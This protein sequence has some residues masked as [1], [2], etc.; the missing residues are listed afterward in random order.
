[1][2]DLT[3]IY[4]TANRISDYF[5]ESVRKNIRETSGGIPIISVSH[6]PIDF[7]QNICIGTHHPTGYLI[8]TQIMIAATFAETEFVVCCED[9]SLY[10]EEHFT[11]R[12]SPG[13]F[14]YN[15]NRWNA[16]GP[17][18]YYRPRA[19][20]CMCIANRDLL[21]I[22]LHQRF[23]KFPRPIDKIAN[24]GEP[25]RK[26]ALLGLPQPP[27]ETFTTEIPCL[28]FNHYDS[29]GGKRRILRAD[30]LCD[31]LPHWGPASE[32][33]KKIHG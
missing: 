8:Y 16:D 33:W 3:V 21:L 10:V 5:A 18:Y 26:D 14:T 12:P 32:L 9:D 17:Y 25:G 20:M 24:F 13:A 11:K 31:T 4:Y 7:G 15:V 23:I 6:K 2:N 28:T 1:M 22:N 19:G 27:L 30:K 29:T